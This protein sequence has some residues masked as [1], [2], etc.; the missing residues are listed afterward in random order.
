MK[1]RLSRSAFWNVAPRNRTQTFYMRFL[2]GPSA[3]IKSA[4][5][6][7]QK[8]FKEFGKNAL[9]TRYSEFLEE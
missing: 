4:F 8:A 2:K 3:E 9:K 6:E 7:S 5:T 1:D